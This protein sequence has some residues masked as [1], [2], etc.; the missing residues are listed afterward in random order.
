MRSMTRR[1]GRGAIALATLL[2]TM[3]LGSRCHHV[4]A[5]NVTDTNGDEL[6]D[7][8]PGHLH[9]WV[10]E[11]DAIAGNTTQIVQAI[12]RHHSLEVLDEL[13][14]RPNAFHVV[15]HECGVTVAGAAGREHHA[16]SRCRLRRSQDW[17]PVGQRTQLLLA[18]PHVTNV[19][20]QPEHVRVRRTGSD[21]LWS[22]QWYLKNDAF[23]SLQQ[24]PVWDEDITGSS[25]VV[26]IVDDGIDYTHP[27]LED[28][29]YP[30]ASFDFNDND[31]DPMPRETSTN[32]NKHGTRCGG[33]VA[34]ARFNGVCGVGIAYT[35][36]LGGIRMLDGP[37]SDVVES[38]SLG[39]ERDVVDVYSCS[40]GP[41]DDGIAFEGPGPLT[42]QAMEH[43]VAFGRSGLG[44]VYIFAGGNGGP[45]D[46]CNADGYSSS[47]HTIAVNS[48]DQTGS[49]P[50]YAESCAMALTSAFSSGTYTTKRIVTSDLH[51]QCTT[52]FSGTS[53][54][55]PQ[56][57][58]I[59]ALALDANPCLSWRHVQDM[60]VRASSKDNLNTHAGWQVNGAGLDVSHQFGFGLLN[61]DTLVTL[62]QAERTQYPHQ[63][64][65]VTDTHRP[66][67]VADHAHSQFDDML[68]TCDDG[69]ASTGGDNDAGGDD[70]DDD[71]N[72]SNNNSGGGDGG[73]TSS[74]RNR[75][76]V[77]RLEHVVV[78]ARFQ[79][80]KRGA[81]QLTLTSPSGT[82]SK[83]LSSRPSDT[84]SLTMT[85]EF[86][87][88]QFWGEGSAGVWR[89]QV[90]SS[91][92][93]ASHTLLAWHMTLY[94]TG[95]N[96][97][98]GKLTTQRDTLTLH[99]GRTCRV[100][101]KGAYPDGVGGCRE[102]SSSCNHGCFG[103]GK[104]DCLSP[105]S[106]STTTS[107]EQ[108]RTT[109]MWAAIGIAVAASAYL[110][111]SFV[112]TR[113]RARV[114]L[115]ALPRTQHDDGVDDDNDGVDSRRDNTGSSSGGRGRGYTQQ[116]QQ[117]QQQQQRRDNLQALQ[118]RLQ[119]DG[120]VH[121]F[122]MDDTCA[123]DREHMQAI[124]E[125][126]MP[127]V[128]SFNNDDYHSPASSV[129]S[130]S[131]P[132]ARQSLHLYPSNDGD[133]SDTAAVAR[134][135]VDG[136]RGR[137]HAIDHNTSSI[138]SGSGDGVA[139]EQ[140]GGGKRAVEYRAVARA[141]AGTTMPG[142]SGDGLSSSDEDDE[143]DVFSSEAHA[144]TSP[145]LSKV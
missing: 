117:Q 26:T 110:A 22:Q 46:D 84:G 29:F 137:V 24:S 20:H 57:A 93:H 126:N 70:D 8:R 76:C 134:P 44:S 118:P 64:R 54:S 123:R 124:S 37:V 129:A 1:R 143:D 63:A 65:I 120:G 107:N 89:L 114:A 112:W 21:P 42:L 11:I 55:A 27:D 109:I 83:L 75:G 32:I 108:L 92:S 91:S 122:D 116:Q 13:P 47:I 136:E 6:Q 82:R 105:L 96:L 131:S 106:S 41:A 121:V 140:F 9:S 81:L 28:N 12:A 98:Q 102:C 58:G 49:V 94:G 7:K 99:N 73:L 4:T 125:T 90:S 139:A 141:R 133:G 17:E 145:L 78:T 85:W 113:C 128:V 10:V 50:H 127:F 74:T 80:A 18:E 3:V 35:S 69:T 71:S 5:S 79:T 15:Q 95:G 31:P 86:G 97:K 119:D 103:P 60:V 138:N 88:V 59:I 66:N 19:M 130:P 30:Q 33:V 77:K 101:P 53:A 2:M 52:T 23:P 62:A 61:A 72:N 43:G 25:V 68:V 100:C 36:K 132:T 67:L 115:L 34:S 142:S 51:H 48:V 135:H 144:L 16:P 14:F 40:W 39:F 38:K 45:T 104:R 111:F 87:S 56:A